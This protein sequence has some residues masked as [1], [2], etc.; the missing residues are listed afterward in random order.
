MSPVFETMTSEFKFYLNYFKRF[1][2]F[3]KYANALKIKE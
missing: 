3:Q 1:G 2:N